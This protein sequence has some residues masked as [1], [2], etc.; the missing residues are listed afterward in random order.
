MLDRTVLSQMGRS[1]APIEYTAQQFED[2]DIT[3]Y[4]QDILNRNSQ[5]GQGELDSLDVALHWTMEVRRVYVRD[6]DTC[7]R[8]LA[9]VRYLEILPPM[10][11]FDNETGLLPTLR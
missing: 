11:W 10:R 4:A 8:L 7:D 6:E 9:Q 2:F 5:L 3:Q 1:I